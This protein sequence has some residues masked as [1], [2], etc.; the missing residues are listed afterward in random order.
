[1]FIHPDCLNE[2]TDALKK[3]TQDRQSQGQVPGQL[4]KKQ[5]VQ[6]EHV[7]GHD[8]SLDGTSEEFR[9]AFNETQKNHGIQKVFTLDQRHGDL[10]EVEAGWL[11]AVENLGPNVKIAWDVIRFSNLRQ[12][13]HSWKQHGKKKLKI[14]EDYALLELQLLKLGTYALTKL[15]LSMQ[16]LE[17]RIQ[18]ST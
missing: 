13:V 18:T 2:F 4:K 9:Q 10:V 14:K 12:Y 16:W 11:H 15:L 8:F 7:E 3:E 1:M 17:L 5:K 6:R